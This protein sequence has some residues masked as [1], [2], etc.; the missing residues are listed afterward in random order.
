MRKSMVMA[1]TVLTAACAGC[2][3]STVTSSRPGPRVLSSITDGATLADAVEWTAHPVGLGGGQVVR[4][5]D[6]LIDGRTRW[7][8]RQ[9][10]YI[11]GVRAGPAGRRLFPWILGPGAH[12]FTVR[13]T[14]SGGRSVTSSARATI[15]IALPV[16]RALIGTFTRRVTTADI[17]RTQR[18]RHEPPDQ[19]LPTGIWRLHIVRTGLIS[20]D[21]PSGSGGNEAF[22][23][24]PSGALTLH[25]PADWLNPPDRQGSFCGLEPDGS[26]SW[27]E[28]AR[29]LT[30]TPHHDTCADR[31]SM[32]S[33]AWTRQ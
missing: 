25:G 23:A 24:T 12:R 2:G 16:P 5:V 9:P 19:V 31:N 14:I 32:F 27:T 18:F 6:F 3:S 7:S 15:D 17:A 8:S 1:V 21:D 29:T 20:F 4:R 11:F 33:G 22:T 30:L 26:W 28:H 13:A 10:P